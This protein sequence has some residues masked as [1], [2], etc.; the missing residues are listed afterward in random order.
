MYIVEPI[1]RDGNCLF[2]RVHPFVAL[3]TIWNIEWLSEDC[4]M[5]MGTDWNVSW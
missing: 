4:D 1:A 5:Y 3:E 2:P